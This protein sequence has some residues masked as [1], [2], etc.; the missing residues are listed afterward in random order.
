MIISI[1]DKIFEKYKRQEEYLVN[2]YPENY[3]NF[4]IDIGTRGIKHPWHIHEMAKKSPETLHIGYEPDVPFFHELE[5]E[6]K[7][8]E[9]VRLSKEGYGKGSIK[10]PDGTCCSVS[11]SDIVDQYE[12]DIDSNWSI[13]FDCEGCEYFLLDNEP[14]IE[15]LKKANHISLEFHSQDAGKN[16]FIS[17]SNMLPNNFN[18]AEEWIQTVFSETHTIFLTTN[19]KRGLRTYV[20]LSEKIMSEKDELFLKDLLP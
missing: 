1:A 13:K 8:L 3:F 16:F 18:V 20:L 7:S 5:R 4:C 14:D 6:T 12:L 10:I 2:H 17:S 19:K 15:I 11:L 9:N